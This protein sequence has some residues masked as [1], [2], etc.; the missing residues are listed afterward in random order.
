MKRLA[1]LGLV[2]TLCLLFIAMLVQSPNESLASSKSAS[3]RAIPRSEN[4][5]F[6]PIAGPHILSVHP[7]SRLMQAKI[8]PTF[9]R[10]EVETYLAHD[11]VAIDMA[12]RK[13]PH[14]IAFLPSQQVGN[15]IDS[16]FSHYAAIL[17]YVEFKSSHSFPIGEVRI[18]PGTKIPRVHKAFEVFDGITGDLIVWGTMP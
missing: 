10:I 18:P 15:L 14:T 5:N 17:C 3:P 13:I 11:A 12:T 4:P 2:C 16:D 6:T 9:T 7:L 8:I 1:I